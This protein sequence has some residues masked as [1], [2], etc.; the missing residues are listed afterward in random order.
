MRSR[1]RARV[2]PSR[3]WCQLDRRRSVSWA[4]S[5]DR[6]GSHR[7]STPRCPTSGSTSGSGES[8]RRHAR[9]AVDVGRAG[10]SPQRG[11]LRSWRIRRPSCTFR[12]S[13]RGRSRRRRLPAGCRLPTSAET[14]LA[15]PRHRRD[16]TELPID[17]RACDRA[18]DL[19]PHH[20]DPFDRML[21]A[22]AQAEGLVL[23]SAQIDSWS[24]TTVEL[25]RPRGAPWAGCRGP[26]CGRCR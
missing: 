1:S 11:P 20:R 14:W 4:S 9:L 19:P 17:I 2:V 23:V 25:L 7:T 13:A 3:A 5:A 8:P 15:D 12:Q 16:V 26:T 24:R 18:G 21:V 22:Q 10:A 6:S